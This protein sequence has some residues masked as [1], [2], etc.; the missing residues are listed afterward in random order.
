MHRQYINIAEKSRPIFTSNDQLRQLKRKI[1][2]V[3][4]CYS[5]CF[6]FTI[7]VRIV[8][9][10]QTNKDNERRKSDELDENELSD[11][12]LIKICIFCL[13]LCSYLSW[14]YGKCTNVSFNVLLSSSV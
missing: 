11:H 10:F 5:I 1:D 4:F 14:P 2:I 7:V 9:E 13:T 12:C 3:L 8:M 6:Y